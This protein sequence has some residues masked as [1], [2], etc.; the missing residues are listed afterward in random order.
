MRIKALSNKTQKK[1]QKQRVDWQQ[2]SSLPSNNVTILNVAPEFSGDVPTCEAVCVLT[3][4]FS[5]TPIH[6]GYNHPLNMSQVS[7]SNSMAQNSR[8]TPLTDSYNFKGIFEAALKDYKEKPKQSLEGHTLFTQFETCDSPA[9]IVNMLRGQVDANTDEGLKKWL[10]PTINVLPGLSRTSTS[11]P[12]WIKVL[13]STLTIP[14]AAVLSCP[15]PLRLCLPRD[16]LTAPWIRSSHRMKPDAM[17]SSCSH[18][19]RL[20]PPHAGSIL[21]QL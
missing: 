1:N 19:V 8:T 14:D 9:A 7:A 10:I 12:C 11:T 4:D 16:G 2:H 21:P 6:D 17:A 13:K 15:C 18:P 5:S 20:Q 3:S